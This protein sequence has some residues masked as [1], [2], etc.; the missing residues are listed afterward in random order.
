VAAKSASPKAV[1]ADDKALG[2]RVQ[3]LRKAQGMTQTQLGRALGVTFQQVQKYEKGLNRIS[4]A[5]INKVCK[6][7]GIPVTELYADLDANS[8]DSIFHLLTI[9]GATELL[10]AYSAISSETGR[11]SILAMARSV[12]AVEA[13][14]AQ[15]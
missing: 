7:L 11:K 15:S 14:T 13:E 3:S 8:E 4:G 12:G 9:K 6:V 2:E 1:N 5:R 10:R